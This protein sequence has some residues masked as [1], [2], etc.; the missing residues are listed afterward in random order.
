MQVAAY[1]RQTAAQRLQRAIE[2]SD[3]THRLALADLKRR[4][5]TCSDE[6]ANRLLAETLYGRK[7]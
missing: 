3:F 5:P 6:E 1:Q 7:K 4:H 2:L